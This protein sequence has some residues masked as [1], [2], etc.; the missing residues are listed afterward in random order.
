MRYGCLYG[1]TVVPPQESLRE[2][3]FAVS[4]FKVSDNRT[5]SA[6]HFDHAGSIRGV[7]N[8]KINE[9]ETFARVSENNAEEIS[10]T[11]HFRRSAIGRS[12]RDRIG[13]SRSLR[14]RTLDR[15]IRT[16]FEN[17]NAF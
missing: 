5:L 10:G 14:A 3:A 7:L 12:R 2:I 6:R 1:P 16:G 11:T 9:T 8:C 17:D 13:R 4:K 15:V